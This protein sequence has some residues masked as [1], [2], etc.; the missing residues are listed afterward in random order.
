M[1]DRALLLVRDAQLSARRLVRFE[2]FRH[3]IEA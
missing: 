3:V 1:H 2:I